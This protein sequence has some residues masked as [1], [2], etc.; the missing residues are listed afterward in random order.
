[1][2]NNINYLKKIDFKYWRS[3]NHFTGETPVSNSQQ[4]FLKL[5]QNRGY[6]I[7]FKPKTGSDYTEIINKNINSFKKD[8][9]DNETLANTFDL[10]Q[11]WGGKNGRGPYVKPKNN[12]VRE[13][14]EN[15]K[16]KYIN[17]AKF[18]LNNDPSNALKEWI[19]IAQLSMG[20]ASK[21]LFFWSGE[22]YPI[23]DTRMS[24]ILTGKKLNN[25]L[26]QYVNANN[27]MSKLSAH[28][29]VCNVETE[30]AVF[31][32]SINFF[33]NSELKLNNNPIDLTDIEIAK[34][35]SEI[36]K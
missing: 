5:L 18:T 8:L 9:C 7:D 25:S 10:I 3:A 24:L 2:T 35:I 31:A 27:L 34:S 21:H 32:F 16:E 13:N 20:F 4:T 19:S 15:W 11:A 23:L 1:M 12:T 14:F 26:D 22:K 30:K 29:H 28:F 6:L 17:G 36:N 33:P